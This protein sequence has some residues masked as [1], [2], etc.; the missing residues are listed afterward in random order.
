VYALVRA[1]PPGQVLTYGQVASLLGLTHGARAVGWALRALDAREA[2]EVP[3]H[4]VLGAGGRVTLP[5]PAGLTQVRRLRAEGVP[6]RA[7]QLVAGR[8]RR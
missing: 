3:W 8:P 1:I 4:R 7:G 6:V 2:R 5:G